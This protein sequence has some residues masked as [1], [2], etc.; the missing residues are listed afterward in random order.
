VLGR[1]AVLIV[2]VAAFAACSGGDGGGSLRQA[3]R[4]TFYGEEAGDNAGSL[5]AGDFN[6]DGDTDAVLAAALADGLDNSRGDGGEAYVFLGPFSPDDTLDAGQGQQDVTILGAGKA[7]QLGRALAAGDLNG[8]G[9][10]DLV[11]GAPFADGPDNG[12]PDSGEVYVVFGS[13]GLGEDKEQLDLAEGVAGFTIL[14]AGDEDLAGFALSVADVSSDGVADLLVGAFWGDGP[15]GERQNAG[16]VYVVYGSPD[17]GGTVDLAAVAP[18]VLVYGAEAEGRLGENVAAGDV[19]GDGAADLVLSASRAPGASGAEGAGRAYVVL[20]PLEPVVDLGADKGATTILG[21]NA[22]D[23][24]G[25]SL[26]VGDVDGDGAADVLLTAA[27]A[28]GGEGEGG[29]TGEAVL[30]LGGPG[31]PALL[32]AGDDGAA[33]LI[34]GA[35]T[36]DSFGRG[37]A[38]GDL[39]GDGLLDLLVAASSGDGGPNGLSNSGKVYLFPGSGQA[40]QSLGPRQTEIADGLDEEDLLATDTF[41]TPS[42]LAADFNGDGRDE[43]FVA[44]AWADGPDNA[45]PD[46][47]EAYILFFD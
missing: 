25:H 18:D 5:V 9:I 44:A 34:Q 43:L 14:G 39:D 2:A 16:E 27:G 35:S 1:L 46:A 38:L 33:S 19:N 7:D 31:L 4:V 47:G 15:K 23:E 36:D 37:A 10:D 17:I 20:S 24:L 28:V 41:G 12:R 29:P 3:G 6:G 11:V 42:L 40:D 30:V 32:K 8:D 45:R 22:G 26:A 21:A 13:E